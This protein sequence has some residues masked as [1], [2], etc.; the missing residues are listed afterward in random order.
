MYKYL[1]KDKGLSV[2]NKRIEI[3]KTLDESTE[4]LTIELLK[5]RLSISMNT[6]TIYRSLRVLVDSGLV[7]QTDFRDGASYFEFHK[8]GNHHHHIVCTSCREMM[9]INLCMEEKFSLIEK[10]TNY[11]INNHVFEIFGLCKKCLE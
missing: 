3:L 2:T 11:K 5:G 4:P 8:R 10:Q 1:I 7:Y 6:S 9:T